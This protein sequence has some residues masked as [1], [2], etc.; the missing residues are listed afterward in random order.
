MLWGPDSPYVGHYDF[1]NAEN[2]DGI[3]E[4]ANKNGIAKG[5]SQ[6]PLHYIYMSKRPSEMPSHTKIEKFDSNS[7]IYSKG[8][9]K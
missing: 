9:F 6:L 3:A 2:T 4:F 5:S 8:I 7:Q 1:C